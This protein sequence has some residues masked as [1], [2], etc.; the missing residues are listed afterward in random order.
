MHTHRLAC[1]LRFWCGLIV[2]LLLNACGPAAPQVEL[3]SIGGGATPVDVVQTFFEE[4]GRA[5]RD[6]QIQRDSVRD[7][8]AARLADYFAPSERDDQRVALGAM[9]DSYASELR[10]AVAL[11]E[12]FTLEIRWDDISAPANPGQRTLVE[13][14][15]GRVFW[16]V[17]RD[18]SLIDEQE[19]PLS[20][21]IGR[22]D[23][24][25]PAVK[26]GTIW[27]LTETYE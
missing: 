26:V 6:P 10:S 21:I 16:Q 15:N 23:S 27:F 18:G 7:R 4:F 22:E 14:E 20:A 1:W 3:G 2:L 5:L 24:S 8:W 25:V 9:L 12:Q 19:T 11:N 13:I 17:L